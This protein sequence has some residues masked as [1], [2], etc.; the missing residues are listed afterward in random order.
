M[1]PSFPSVHLPRRANLV[2]W[3]IAFVYSRRASFCGTSVTQISS[4]IC[5]LRGT[6]LCVLLP[7]QLSCWNMHLR[8]LYFGYMD[9]KSCTANPF[10][11]VGDGLH[12]LVYPL[13]NSHSGMHE[14][15]ARAEPSTLLTGSSYHARLRKVR[16]VFFM[17]LSNTSSLN[18]EDEAKWSSVLVMHSFTSL[19]SSAIFFF[20]LEQLTKKKR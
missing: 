10:L 15:V 13:N 6:A 1:G 17:K 8:S 7:Q 14:T 16:Y 5:V 3:K 11:R 4:G 12:A 18:S 20:W 9:D 2:I 19:W